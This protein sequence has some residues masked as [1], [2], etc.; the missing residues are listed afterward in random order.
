M[1]T[2]TP[3]APTLVLTIRRLHID[4]KQPFDRHWNGQDAFRTAF[5]NA[6]SMSFPVGEQ[7]FIDSI[8]NALPLLRA[9]PHC[10]GLVQEAKSF[11]GQESTHRF[12]H[13]QFN[14][15]LALQGYRNR[16]ESRAK[17]HIERLQRE[18]IQRRVDQPLLHE[19][20][21][22][23]A[24]EHLTAIM[25]DTVMALK[26]T[27]HDWFAGAQ[28]P[29]RTLWYWHSAEEAEHKALAF[30]V[31]T[32]LGGG[33]DLRMYYYWRMLAFFTIDLTL[34]VGDNLW[35]DGSWRRAST[36]QHATRFLFGRCGLLAMAGSALW[37]YRREDFHP[38]HVGQTER[39]H[40]WLAQNQVLWTAVKPATAD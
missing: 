5:A 19:L 18:I 36:W 20:A 32:A 11:M 40:A 30:D 23:C 33:R 12:I 37:A 34:Q 31:Y 22:T 8:K 16:W 7:F 24:V 4:L 38:I 15:R 28:E 35:R 27:P 25:G 3:V 6:L 17:R 9:L 2:F 26:D 1:S 10:E 21:V 39:A 13:A 29:V 14:E